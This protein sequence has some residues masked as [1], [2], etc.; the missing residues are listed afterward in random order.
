MS[1]ASGSERS[2]DPRE[3][4]PGRP[5][6]PS[7][8]MPGV[9]RS[10][11]RVGEIELAVAVT[12]E[13]PPVLL[14]HGYPQ[15]HVMWR[16][17]VDRL[18]AE[19]TLVMPDLR[20]YGQSEKPPGDSRH[21]TY[22]KRAMAADAL[23]LM[24]G[25]GHERFAVVGH[26]RGARVA[27]RLAL[28]AP[29]VVRSLAVLDIVPTHYLF[30]HVD[31]PL[32]DGYFHWF[33][34][35]QPELPERLIGAD[36]EGWTR[37]VLDRWAGDARPIDPAAVDE[38]VAGMSSPGAVHASCEDYRAAASI[39]LELD[40]ADVSAGRRV[41]APLLALWG[42]EGRMGQLYDVGR[43]WTDYADEVSGRA[44]RG[45]HFVAEEAPEET[46]DALLAFLR[47]PAGWEAT[48]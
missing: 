11:V 16:H 15:T 44:V 21:T 4:L 42:D 34:L 18:A 47:D 46:S 25:L 29:G 31:R 2:R 35:T 33:F 26:D 14:L 45:G 13:G 37:W 43:I 7:P 3:R 24:E 22:S 28:D 9:A 6:A 1:E 32:A 30:H 20:G 48:L 8:I 38:Y 12:G 19:H 5:L 41:Q 40:D 27:H 36:I 10:L 17:V 39:D 23:R